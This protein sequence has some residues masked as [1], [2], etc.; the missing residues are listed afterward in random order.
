MYDECAIELT[1]IFFIFDP[2]TDNTEGGFDTAAW[3]MPLDLVVKYGIAK[4]YL[5][6]VSAA[7]RC[8]QHLRYNPSLQDSWFTFFSSSQP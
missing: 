4:L 3:E 8:F 2:A 6:D 5:G 1:C 7:T